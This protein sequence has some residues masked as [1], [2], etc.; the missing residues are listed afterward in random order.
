MAIPLTLLRPCFAWF[1]P[2]CVNPLTMAFW[3]IALCYK[4]VVEFISLYNSNHYTG[5]CQSKCYEYKENHGLHRPLHYIT[6]ITL[7]VTIIQVFCLGLK[8][9]VLMLRATSASTVKLMGW[10]HI[11]IRSLSGCFQGQ[12]RRM[13]AAENMVGLQKIKADVIKKAWKS[14]Y[15]IFICGFTC[16]PVTY[17]CRIKSL[18]K[19]VIAST[20]LLESVGVFFFPKRSPCL[21]TSVLWCPCGR[22]VSEH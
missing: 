1:H 7:L 11:H 8:N 6:V 18:G 20:D 13:V 22:R 10:A 16:L 9:H 17:G 19:C 2:H 15:Q 5:S 14:P 4:W 21:S 12:R 3:L